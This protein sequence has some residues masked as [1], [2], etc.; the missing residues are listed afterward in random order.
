MTF[1]RMRGWFVR[2]FGVFRRNK[3]DDDF[4]AELESH[5]Q[6]HIDDNLS[7]GM[8]PEEARRQ[9][10]I[11]LGGIEP[12][13]EQYRTQQTLPLIET[14]IRDLRFAFRRLAKSP[15]L[16]SI[17][18]LSLALGIG[19][20]TAIFSLVNTAALR[21]LPIENPDQLV[22]LTNTVEDRMFPVFSYPNYK[23]IRDRNEVFDGL[24]AYRFAPL[25]LSHDGINERV[26]GYLVSGNYFDL[27]GVNASIGRVITPEDDRVPG[28]HP[29]TVLSYRAWK[30]RF[31]SDPAIIGKNV[32]VNGRGYDVIGVAP[33]GFNGTEII[34]APELWFP[35][36]MQAE[37]DVGNSW[38][39][40]RGIQNIFVQG[41]LKPGVS[42]EQAQ[43]RIASIGAQL[44][45]EF[46][47][48]NEGKRISL[49]TPGFMGGT[50]R[51]MVLGFTGMLMVVVAF[52]LLLACTNLANLLLARATT[53]RKE[54]A[55]HLALGASRPR[56]IWQLMSESMLLAIGGGICG[57][58][59]AYWL[60]R[61][62]VVFKLPMDVPLYIN[63]QMDHRVL[64][65]TLAISLLTGVLIGLLPALQA[66]RVDVQSSLKDNTSF[67]SFRR[68]WWKSSLI[69][70]QVVLSLVLLIGAGLTLRALQKAESLDLGFK[71]ENAV[72][73]SFDLRLQGYDS[74][75]SREFLKTLLEKLRT[76]PNVQSAGIVDLVPVDLHFS[77]QSVFAEGQPVERDSKAP[78]AMSSR[79][80]PGYFQAMATPLLQ[81]RDFTDQDDENSLPVAIVNETFAR[82]FWPGQDPI[83]KRFS[84]GSA[85]SQKMQIV[86]MVRDGKY[87]GLNEQP[88]PYFSRPIAQSPMGPVTLVVRT[89]SDP[90]RIVAPIRNLLLQMDPHLPI[91]SAK[92]LNEKMALP[93]LPAR[94]AAWVLGI[95]GIVALALAAIGIYGVMSYAV[96]TRMHEI[97]IRVALGARASDVLSLTIGQGMT[98]VL[99]GSV[100]G[101]SVALALTRLAKSMLF[102]V[103][104][105]DPLTY[106][107]VALLLMAVS[108]LAC[109]IPAHRGTKIDPVLALRNE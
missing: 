52:V 9:A 22:S 48:E 19:A 61:M 34:S 16:T 8:T 1:G 62:A 91:A 97:G 23:D 83:G 93:L 20:N 106:A 18:L 42:R 100:I 40:E 87:G 85:D 82:R 102:G 96:S 38:L 86:G 15:G 74:S 10:L 53:R 108:L 78:R 70:F 7:A 43:T 88:Q 31:G 26:W 80:S 3:K 28:G 71:P 103:S 58:L 24:L 60:I 50:M 47:K 35:M 72:A 56:L 57:S 84:M 81:G 89:Y 6:M 63:L 51:G 109:F 12:T 95:L 36:A 45:R 105:A 39:N 73:V 11:K 99:I 104:S 77:R 32:I 98:L 33:Q 65:F 4:A 55:V 46:P 27:L 29:V 67:G 25:S 79:I 37:I 17:A 107:G 66:T 14:M 41:R 49:S 30:E 92:T 2:L 101:I 69:V 76:F 13:K 68:S 5:L 44:V 64:L 75:R 21:P 90:H 94:V 54:I 59:L